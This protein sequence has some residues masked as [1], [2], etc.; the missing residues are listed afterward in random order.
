MAKT[1]E[2]PPLKST[3][4]CS[5]RHT[6][7]TGSTNADLLKLAKSGTSPGIVLFT[8]H[9]TAGKGRQNRTWHDDP[10]NALLVSVLLTP[11]R[12]KAPVIPF[13]VGMAAVDAVAQLV[14]EPSQDQQK[15]A[16][17]DSERQNLS[18]PG[19][20]MPVG[21]KWPNDILANGH[22]E[23]K[24]AGILT[25]STPH[26]G[27]DEKLVVVAGMGLNIRWSSQPLEDVAA[28]ITLEEIL[29]QAVERTDLLYSYL[30][31]LEKWLR[32]LEDDGT[33]ALVDN[34]RRYCVTLGQRVRFAT[35]TGEV[36]GLVDDVVESGALRITTGE[37]SVELFAGDAH[38][39]GF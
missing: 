26:S 24:L 22:G 29:G 38:H 32:V 2:L 13:A 20:N 15:A 16:Q 34:Y 36:V 4:F 35:S 27:D 30:T 9:Q 10:G 25:E 5:I 28:A 12:S 33:R 19:H 21:L 1:T 6:T 37:E 31:E 17:H 39:L 23:R 11:D 3:R 18:W 14:G 8:D 7:E